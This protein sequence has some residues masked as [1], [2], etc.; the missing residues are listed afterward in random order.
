[1]SLL[2]D[3]LTGYDPANGEAAAAADAQ[4]QQLNARDYGVGGKFYS[5]ANLAAVTAQRAAE[6]AQNGDYNPDAQR[7]QIDKA[8]TDKLDE[9]AKSI[10]GGPL[11]IV[12]ATIKSVLKSIPWWVW[13]IGFVAVFLW[14]GGGLLVRAFIKKKAKA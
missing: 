1:M 12:W 7:A 14:L 3:W 11:G 8:F 5:D 9:Q 10:I 6:L 4:L 13:L 2:P